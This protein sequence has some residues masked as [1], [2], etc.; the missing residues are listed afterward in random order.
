MTPHVCWS[1]YCFN[2][3]LTSGQR[4]AS[5]VQRGSPLVLV[6]LCM[7]YPQLC[8]L[9]GPSKHFDGGGKKGNWDFCVEPCVTRGRQESL[10]PIGTPFK[11]GSD[12][13]GN[14]HGW[15]G[16]ILAQ[17]PEVLK[18]R[19]ALWCRTNKVFVCY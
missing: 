18:Y 15:A 3:V 8:G 2:P 19:Q 4:I 14:N 13:Y 5:Q 11:H 10:K 12:I 1:V 16:M 9:D 17:K 7:C 6:R